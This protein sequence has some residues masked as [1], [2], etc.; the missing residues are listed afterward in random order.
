MLTD[1]PYKIGNAIIFNLVVY[2]MTNLRREPGAFFFFLLISFSMT[3]TM[4][5]VFRTI[6]ASSR[7]LSQ[8]LAP[9]ALLILA[10]VI[11]TGFTIPTPNMLGWA[12][13]INY[14][15]PVGYGFES[16]MIN[17]FSS[18]SFLCDSYVPVGPGYQDVGVTN[19]ICSAVGS[20]A[21][22]DIVSGDA[23]INN[24]FQYFSSHKWR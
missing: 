24:S 10:I 4:S 12:R 15:D 19:R 9:A 20:A 3:L 8:A 14:L 6:A 11:Y 21:G 7:T 23:Y 2:F 5:M 13:W 16:L 1:I 17:E 22:A 18:K